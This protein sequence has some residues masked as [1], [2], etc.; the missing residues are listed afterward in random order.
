MKNQLTREVEAG[1]EGIREAI[2][3]HPSLLTKER[4]QDSLGRKGRTGMTSPGEG[5]K[6]LLLLQKHL[7]LIVK[8]IDLMTE[9][10]EKEVP[11][12]KTRK[13]KDRD[14]LHQAVLKEGLKVEMV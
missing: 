10:E 8:E 11:G 2:H 13:E 7:R 12:E 6:D 5:E 1:S 14:L 9:T 3:C 4:N